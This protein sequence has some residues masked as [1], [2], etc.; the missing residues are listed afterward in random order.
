MS[1]EYDLVQT[2]SL[3]LKGVSDGGISKKKK[4]K[5]KKSK[6]DEREPEASESSGSSQT[7][8]EVKDS[9]GA[10]DYYSKKTKTEI[11]FLKKKEKLEAD[12]IRKKATETHKD[13]VE[14]FNSYLN[15]LSEHYEQAK[16]SWTK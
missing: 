11:A 2:S 7:L 4:K 12:R 6:H 10:H 9:S 8:A 14:K 1:S 3:K 13:R 15:N 5:C 16:V